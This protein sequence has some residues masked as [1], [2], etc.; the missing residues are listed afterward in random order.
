MAR[1]VKPEEFASKRG[2]I[3]DAA[4]RLVIAN[5]YEHMAIQDILD[6]LHISSGAFH[7]Y[8]DSRGALVVALAERM[9]DEIEQRVRPIVQDPRLPAGEKLR[10]FFATVLR[11][12]ITPEAKTLVNALLRAWFTDEN[13]LIRQKVDAARVERLAPLLTE[14]VRQ[15]VQEARFT[16]LHPELAGEIILYLIQGLQYSLARLHVGVVMGSDEP[17]H[18]E[19]V[20]AVYEAYMDT[21][22]RT[23]GVP[24]GL[25]AHLDAEVVHEA[26]VE[27]KGGMAG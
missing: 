19:E 2:D 14:I 23:L 8:F 1:T 7:H 13:A 10:R 4:Q 25:L 22:E 6:E 3:L 26:V 11:Q 20:L 16:S 12:E 21:I 9:Q 24:A 18:V 15:G 17:R 27:D 5:G